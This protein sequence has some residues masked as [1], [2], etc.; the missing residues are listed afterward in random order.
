MPTRP[1][2]LSA[3]PAPSDAGA[4]ARDDRRWALGV[5]FLYLVLIG[6]AALQHEL[7]RDE[8]QAWLIARDSPTL[9][10]LLR[11]IRHEGHPPGWYLPLYLLARFTR[12]PLAMQL[13]HVGLAATGVFLLARFAPLPR[14]QKL[15]ILG[16][17]FIAYEYA[18]L[19]RAY[20]L[21]TVGLFLF[22]ATAR[23]RE[24]HLGMLLFGLLLLASSTF[25]GLLIAAVAGAALAVDLAMIRW[26]EGRVLGPRSR[27]VVGAAVVVAV[28]LLL[29]LYPAA[30]R[31]V[32]T[33]WNPEDAF[34]RWAV[35]A[36]FSKLVVAYLP[37]PDLAA[38]QVWSSHF[39]VIDTR[40][41]LAI[42][43]VLSI[44]IF[45]G[46]VTMFARKPAVLFFYMAGS[47][48]LIAFNHFV[49]AGT[50]RHM[51]QL[52]MVFVASLWLAQLPFAKWQMPAS[53]K[54]WT[55][56]R[57]R[58]AHVLLGVVF[59]V[60]IAT[61]ATLLAADLRQPFSNAPAAAEVLRR[62][63]LADLPL[64]ASAA[65]NSSPIAGLLDR[66]IHYLDIGGSGTFVPWEAYRRYVGWARRF[67][68]LEAIVAAA[69]GEAVLI[70]VNGVGPAPT[71]LEFDT[72]AEVPAGLI[73]SE[74]YILYR[75]R[76][77]DAGQPR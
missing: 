54:R 29:L 33:R 60:Q 32:I 56:V 11:N 35:A 14:A 5:T 22:C 51:G 44:A 13:L 73:I 69:G 77:R 20:A 41:S 71:A 48:A 3:G 50:V 45:L 26:H 43:F 2:P 10:D 65:P 16:S 53:V 21:G 8:W 61:S 18:V 37:F 19:S 55:G 25:Y 52:F 6:I 30:E 31:Y 68:S 7:W 34:S 76:L 58:G 24:R 40:G 64:T 15:L 9:A 57:T 36:S 46:G 17:Y 67:E 1:G 42:A 72:I 62:A 27:L 66:P 70:T 75:V 4:A 63:E 49:F 39:L 74:R 23:H 47:A 59:T 28:A 38:N 12:D